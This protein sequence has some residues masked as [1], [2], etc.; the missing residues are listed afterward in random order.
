MRSNFA[1]EIVM[2]TFIALALLASI[3]LSQEAYRIPFATKGNTIELIVANTSPVV[4]TQVSLSHQSPPVEGRILL[5]FNLPR[6]FSFR[7]SGGVC[8][9]GSVR[10]M[11]HA[12]SAGMGRS[13]S[14]HKRSF[15]PGRQKRAPTSLPVN[16]STAAS[17]ACRC[18]TYCARQNK[19]SKNPLP[20]LRI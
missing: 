7:F 3:S 11:Q 16:T 5:P 18:Y 10:R 2:R 20:L 14:E 19:T 17:V 13:L 8:S 1:R 12:G 4:A 9:F 15:R 6:A